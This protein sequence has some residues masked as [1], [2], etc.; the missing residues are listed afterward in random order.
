MDGG[1]SIWGREEGGDVLQEPTPLLCPL[2]APGLVTTLVPLFLISCLSASS[3]LALLTTPSRPPLLF[4][5]MSA[6]KRYEIGLEKLQFTEQQVGG[7]GRR[8]RREG[9]AGGRGRREEGRAPQWEV[10]KLQFTEQQVGSGH[11]YH[12]SRRGEASTL[13]RRFL[14]HDDGCLS[15]SLLTCPSSRSPP[16]PLLPP[17]WSSCKRS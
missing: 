4:Q 8:G 3:F 14:P 12:A 1:D 11:A 6:K 9:G 5:V 16:L 7:L 2:T 13:H 15:P 17:R 10:E